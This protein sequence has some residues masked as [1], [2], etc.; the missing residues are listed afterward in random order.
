MNFL[1]YRNQGKNFEDFF[2]KNLRKLFF[3][4]MWDANFSANGI[5]HYGL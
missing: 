5:A 1:G 2:N 4:L 3:C